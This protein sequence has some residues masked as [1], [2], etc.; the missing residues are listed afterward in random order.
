[1]Y[2]FSQFWDEEREDKY[3][4]WGTSTW[5]FETNDSDNVLKQITVYEN[6]KILKYCKENPKDEYG[7][8]A[9]H[10]LTIDDCDG[11]EISKEEFLTIWS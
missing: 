7:N 11:V 9:T 3:A 10:N 2:Y 5:Y 4:S 6:G 8:L 1:M